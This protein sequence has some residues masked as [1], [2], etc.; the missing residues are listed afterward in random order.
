MDVRR[1]TA[2]PERTG[3]VRRGGAPAPPA[4]EYNRPAG[5]RA[6]LAYV[7]FVDAG[8]PAPT[9]CSGSPGYT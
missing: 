7:V 1:R 2:G 6:R 9:G 3:E 4:A 8:L 5:D